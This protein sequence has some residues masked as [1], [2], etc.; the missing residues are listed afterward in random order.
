[1]FDY[2]Y[3]LNNLNDECK[4]IIQTTFNKASI[5]NQFGNSKSFVLAFLCEFF[6]LNI[7]SFLL[8]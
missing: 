6:S 2:E 1:M 7:Y 3:I 5:D 8:F 4:S